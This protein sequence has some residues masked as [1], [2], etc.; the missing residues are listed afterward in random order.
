MAAGEM[1]LL[2]E[3]L[4]WLEVWRSPYSKV[5]INVQKCNL[6]WGGVPS[7]LDRIMAIEGTSKI[8]GKPG[9]VK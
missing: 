8:K 5:H 3:G 2:L 9:K 6:G 1:E 4:M 7:E